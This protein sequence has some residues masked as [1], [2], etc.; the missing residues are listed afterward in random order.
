[1]TI[2][3]LPESEDDTLALVISGTL[4]SEDYDKLRPEMDL[5]AEAHDEFDLLCELDDVSGLQPSAIRDDLMFVKDYAG[6]LRKMAVVTDES[7]L[8]RVAQLV[9]EPVAFVIG[10]DY[11]RFDDRVEAWKWLRSDA[12]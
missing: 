5:R 11:E 2:E 8:G 3:I 12:G 7:T 9:G 4:T 1:M 10:V 6:S